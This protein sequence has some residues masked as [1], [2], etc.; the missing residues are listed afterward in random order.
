MRREMRGRVTLV[1]GASRGIGK[2]VA[3]QLARL[4]ARLA[5]TARSADELAKLASDLRAAGTEV[6]AIPADLIRPEDR[7]HLVASVVASN[8]RNRRAGARHRERSALAGRS[9]PRRA[10]CRRPLANRR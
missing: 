9:P 2:R 6:E 8:G 3:D 10:R 7:E 1:T 5:I 4:G